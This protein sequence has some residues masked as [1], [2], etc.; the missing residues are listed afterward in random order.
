MLG[1]FHVSPLT[2]GSDPSV[3]RQWIFRLVLLM[4]VF[5]LFLMAVG[6]ATRVMDAGLACP[7]WPLCFGTLVPQMD[8]QIF[9]EWFHRL[10]ATSLGL[11]AIAFVGLSVAWRQA[12]PPWVPSAAAA[13]LCLVIV[14]G[15]LGGLTVTELLRFEIVTAH[16]GTGLL[17]FCLLAAI[18]VG[19]APFRGTGSARWL[20]I[21]AVIAALCVYGQSLLGGLVSSQWAVHQCLYGDRLC[22]VLNSHLIG[23]V[24]A[25]LSVLGVVIVAWRSPA[26]ASLLRQLSFSLLPVVAL[27]VA[28]G[29]S[30]LQLKLQVPALTVAHQM[31]GATLL[32]VLVAISTLA[33][34]DCPSGSLKHKF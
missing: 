20:R 13:A 27:Q 1:P 10:L 16:L 34:R 3:R 11:M 33:W 18:T 9:L 17:F 23:A 31:I 30:T 15:I 26:L 4:T 8:L 24:P 7:D 28:L 5:T 6:S 29:W 22:V 19:F 14:Q 2:L 32:G 25:T 21:A 12:L